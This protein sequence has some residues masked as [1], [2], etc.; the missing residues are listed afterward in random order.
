M[1]IFRCEQIKEIDRYTITDEPVSSVDLMERAA[2]KLYEWIA[3]RFDRSKRIVV[4]AGP[5]NN[6]GDGLALA[7]FLSEGRYNTEVHLVHC[8]GKVSDDW[9]VNRIRLEQVDKVLF[10]SISKIDQFPVICSDDII[11][12]AIFGSGLMRP[13]EGLEA[14]IIRE[15]NKTDC[16]VIA[17]D[18]PSGLFGE[19]NGHNIPDNIINA[20]YTLSFQFPKL[21]FLFAENNVYVGECFVLPIGLHPVAIRDIE[22]PFYFLEGSDIIQML[23]RRGKFDHK[24]NFGHGLI[25]S[26]SQIMTG[27][28][29]LAAK[30]ALRSGIGLIT[31]HVPSGSGSVIQTYLPEAMIRPDKNA[32]KITNMEDTKGFSSIGVGPGIG[33][34]EVTQKAFHNLLKTC[35][36][37]IVLD[38]DAINILGLNKDWIS[39][40]QPGTILTPHLKEFERIAGRTGDCYKRLMKQIAL[41]KKHKCIIVLKGAHTSVSLPDGRVCFNST[42]NPGMATAGSGDVLTGIILSLLAQE[43]SQEEAAV[44]AVYIHGMAGDIAAEKSCYE[45]VIASD[46][47]ENIGNAFKRIR[48]MFI[49]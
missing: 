30:A 13:V 26:G 1:K 4:F 5:G 49:S 18:I 27:A 32:T 7:R 14:E 37:P 41:S 24:G 8:N 45:S 10:N 6:G 36:K 19:D 43:Y 12:D 42:G 20:D 9:K 31:C 11:I 16:T 2:L 28:A 40:I 33:T 22:T 44:T 15:I 23:K 46:I 34:E 29:V 3:R 35:D 47:I 48:D 25:I 21:S 38:A 39:L 17:I